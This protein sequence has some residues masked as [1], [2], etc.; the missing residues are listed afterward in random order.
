MSIDLIPGGWEWLE[1]NAPARRFA[2]RRRHPQYAVFSEFSAGKERQQLSIAE[3]AEERLPGQ[4]EERPLERREQAD[5]MH[6]R[7]VDP[8]S[9]FLTLL[10]LWNHLEE[11]QRELSGNAFRRRCRAEFLNYLR[12]REWQDLHGQLRVLERQVDG[13]A[14]EAD[15][16]R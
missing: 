1:C 14:L 7:F 13:D 12:V 9:D 5:A 10:N 15:L 4:L 2:G 6:A 3:T 11:Q 16:D 8:T